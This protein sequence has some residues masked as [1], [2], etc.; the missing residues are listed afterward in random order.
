[1][2]DTLN[3]QGPL[4]RKFYE[5]AALNRRPVLCVGIK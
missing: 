3:A 5:K 4:I 2:A 1:M